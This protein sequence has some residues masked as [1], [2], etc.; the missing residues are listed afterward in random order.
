MLRSPGG[1]ILCTAFRGLVPI[2]ESLLADLESGAL[3]IYRTQKPLKA[4]VTKYSAVSAK[5]DRT[6]FIF[7]APQNPRLTDQGDLMTIVESVIHEYVECRDL[8][9]STACAA[10]LVATPSLFQVTSDWAHLLISTRL[11]H[12][13]VDDALAEFLTLNTGNVMN[14]KADI[15][16]KVD[17]LW[18]TKLDPEE[19]H[20]LISL[21]KAWWYIVSEVRVTARMPRSLEKLIDKRP[22]LL[23]RY[24][25]FNP[26]FDLGEHICECI[27][28]SF[29]AENLRD[30]YSLPG[31]RT[32]QPDTHAHQSRLLRGRNWLRRRVD[33]VL[34]TRVA[35]YL[36][37]TADEHFGAEI[38]QFSAPIRWSMGCLY[39]VS[40]KMLDFA[41]DCAFYTDAKY[42]KGLMSMQQVLIREHH[43]DIDENDSSRLARVETFYGPGHTI[44]TTFPDFDGIDRETGL[45]TAERFVILG[46]RPTKWKR[47]NATP[48]S[49]AYYKPRV[50]VRDV[51]PQLVTEHILD[52]SGK[53]TKTRIY[54]YR[55]PEAALPNTRTIYEGHH[56][57]TSDDSALQIEPLEVHRFV[58]HG[59]NA[60]VGSSLLILTAK[61][62]VSFTVTAKYVYKNHRKPHI[63]ERGIFTCI[64]GEDWTWDITYSPS[65]LRPGQHPRFYGITIKRNNAPTSIHTRLDYS[66]PEHVRY[67]TVEQAPG[68]PPRSVPTP[69][70]ILEDKYGLLARQPPLSFRESSDFVSYGL[71]AKKTKTSFMGPVSQIQFFA[72][73]YSTI[74]QREALWVAWRSGDIPAPFARDIDERLLR[75]E[76]LLNGYWWR[77]D[78]GMRASAQELLRSRKHL[79]TTELQLT[80]QAWTRTHLQLRYGDL[81]ILGCGGDAER[82]S[83]EDDENQALLLSGK[84]ETLPVMN[85]DSGTWP[86]GG[87]GVG[88][89]R[90]DLIAGL[91][92]IRWVAYCELGS[93]DLVQKDYPIERHIDSIKYIPLWDL[94]FGTPNE[95]LLRT[96][97]YT[98][99]Q[100]KTRYTSQSIIE[101]RFVPLITKLVQGCMGEELHDVDG[102]ER[103]F[104]EL[105]EVVKAH[106]WV[107]LWNNK[108]TQKAWIEGWLNTS[109]RYFEE[110][111]LQAAETPTL[112]EVE[113]LFDLISRLLM[114]LSME[115]PKVP[116]IH[117]S[118]HGIQAIV[119]VIAK[120][121]NGCSL[122]VWDHGIL[123]R[124]RLFGLCFDEGMPRFAQII[125]AGFNRLVAKIVFV[126]ADY[127]TPCTSI[128]NV[129]WEAWIGGG[130]DNDDRLT[131]SLYRR[132]NPVLNGM[133]V[134]KFR[135]DFTKSPSVPT[136][137][138]LSHISPVKDV[139]NAI[140]ATKIIV[141][142]FHLES[143]QLH[144][145]GSPQKDPPY[146]A[147]CLRAIA[148]YGL[149]KN[150]FLKGLGSPSAVL[151]TGHVFVNSSIT[152]GLP[153]ALGEAGLCGLPVVCTD[154]GGSREVIRDPTSKKTFGWVVPPSRPRQLALGQLRVLAMTD[155]LEGETASLNDFLTADG[156]MLCE[157][158]MAPRISQ[159]R[160]QLGLG[161]RNRIMSVFSINRYWR[162]HEQ[163]LWLGELHQKVK[164]RSLHRESVLSIGKGKRSSLTIF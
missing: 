19:K 74:A 72:R 30:L 17:D 89:C 13:E 108:A 18:R 147:L 39:A 146:T 164:Q 26:S 63:P 143:Y 141:R 44:I 62:G 94:D 35:L 2:I 20:F 127:I 84:N 83:P 31:S 88:S 70:E 52:G 16:V 152:E 107:T 122:I 4:G 123:W 138:M 43:F 132:I 148:N 78:F 58:P 113:M 53:V 45:I 133:N 129:D 159:L 25:A 145:Y 73:A 153:L 54:G 162:E 161:L 82:L 118:H 24:F 156:E 117:S 50:H 28:L 76:K 46:M 128:Q 33:A 155:G 93:A 140:N 99:L 22:K 85:L 131:R 81:H 11:K 104:V 8:P 55:S 142:E 116:V 36:A 144:I 14:G 149:E 10:E 109:W 135:P 163:V 79:L 75:K 59:T 134:D 136:A 41:Q 42:G 96:V 21:A 106:D 160:T 154:V 48:Q 23:S 37:L 124:E 71:R 101:K 158:I 87:G 151:P 91:P 121:L 12:Q 115:L 80:D 139:M 34:D 120:K 112:R 68:K 49:R 5:V 111:Q 77:R 7:L 9:H 57:P 29:V 110:H 3:E 60:V 114:A 130:K 157:R 100:A 90:R 92:R 97:P 67:E 105:H 56:D 47:G 38:T 119:G 27:L 69:S 65:S 125:F 86:T 61:N 103:M 64:S 1:H 66:H 137:V 95:N 98:Q 15:D 150:V 6:T 126:R 32:A 40:R 102:Y 51:A